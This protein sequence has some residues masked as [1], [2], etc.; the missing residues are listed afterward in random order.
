MCELY[1]VVIIG[2]GPAGLSTLSALQESF[3]I[4][5]MTDSKYMKRVDEQKEKNALLTVLITLKCNETMYLLD[6]ESQRRD[7]SERLPLLIL[8]VNG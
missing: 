2:A 1:D 3:S 8:P 7:Q 5:H 6:G 4:D